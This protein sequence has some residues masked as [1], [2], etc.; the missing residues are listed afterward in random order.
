MMET[1]WEGCTCKPRNAKIVGHDPELEGARKD[2][3]LR[4]PG[5]AWPCQHLDVRL[6]SLQNW[7]MIHFCCFQ[8]SNMCRF[9]TAATRL[10][11]TL[12]PPG[13]QRKEIKRGHLPRAGAQVKEYNHC[14][15]RSSREQGNTRLDLSPL[16][17][18]NFP[19]LLPLV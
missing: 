18:S 8:P 2:P 10:S 7:E 13:G 16:P 11:Y 1:E 12:P 19:L 3:P 14:Q 15:L 17:L 4:V 6:S 9:V 5:G